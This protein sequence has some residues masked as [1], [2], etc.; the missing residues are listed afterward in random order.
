MI[1]RVRGTLLEK[2][3]DSVL[4]EAGGL[5]YE[6]F[7]PAPALEALGPL[8]SE[9][10]LYTHFQVREDAQA[11]YGFPSPLERRVFLLLMTVKGV[12]PRVALAVLSRLGAPGAL[13]ALRRRDTAALVLVPG[14]GRK[15][16][17]RLGV[18]LSDKAAEEVPEGGSAPGAA[19]DRS[20]DAFVLA[21]EA[22]QGLGFPQPLARRRVEEASRALGPSASLEAL[23]REALRQA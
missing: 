8:G 21:V 9:V 6:V 14:V 17:E 2:G 16:A 1:A 22:L 20:A 13:G 7:V 11:L 3:A 10:R 5:A 19:P 4:V 12:G 23:V 18:E 15:L